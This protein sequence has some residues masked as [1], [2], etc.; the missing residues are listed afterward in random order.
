MNSASRPPL[1]VDAAAEAQANLVRA[2]LNAM[3]EAGRPPTDEELDALFD[4]VDDFHRRVFAAS[5]RLRVACGRGCANCCSQMV[6][7]VNAFEVDRIGR[8][9]VAEGRVEDV[10]A[11]LA[12]RDA[13]YRHDR[14]ENPRRRDEDDDAWTERVA[15]AFWRRDEPCALLDDDGNC[16]VH[17]VRP[18]S[19]RRS[20]AGN[21]PALCR[22]EHARDPRRRFFTLAPHE[23]F[24]EEL[25]ALDHWAPYAVDSDR[26]DA[27]LLR[28]IE[29]NV[30]RRG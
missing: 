1:A 15:I 10:R 28:W 29:G 6:F 23:T 30:T 14:L 26:L 17:D 9:L 16:S 18:W 19:C 7:D 12:E 11:R 4:D 5:D 20:F 2:R 8:R 3:L 13:R 27:A 24:D 25:Q 22:G 21:D